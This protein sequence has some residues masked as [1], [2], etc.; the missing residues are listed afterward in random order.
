MFGLNF[1]FH[2]CD[3][4]HGH[5]GPNSPCYDGPDL[6]AMAEQAEQ[7][8]RDMDLAAYVD[9]EGKPHTPGVRE[10]GNVS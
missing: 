9:D 10:G 5:T 3:V 1:H 7:D 4:C 2:S 8:E 6:E